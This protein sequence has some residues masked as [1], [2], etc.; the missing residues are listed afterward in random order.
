VQGDSV[1]NE[2][3][4]V[5]AL[6]DAV[7]P[8]SQVRL[9]MYSWD[10]VDP[11]GLVEG[12]LRAQCQLQ[13]EHWQRETGQR[14]IKVLNFAEC[15]R[16]IVEPR[17][18]L[19]AVFKSQIKLTGYQLIRFAP[20]QQA[21]VYLWW[22]T[23]VEPKRNYSAFVHLLSADGDMIAQFDHLPLSSFYPMLAWPTGVDLRDDSPLNLPD[24]VALEGAWLAVG[25]YNPSSMR[26]LEARV[27]GEDVGDFVRIPVE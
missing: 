4:V 6:N 11:Q 27:D 14:P 5:E 13:G 22:Q 25:L 10:T 7:T 21:H 23:L 2:A 15:S 1:Q 19:D 17:M 9:V 18:P 8:G 3:E 26:R 16:F 12:A 24:D 20:G